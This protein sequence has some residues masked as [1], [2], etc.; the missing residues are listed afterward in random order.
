MSKQYGCH[1]RAPFK[2]YHL[3]TGADNLRKY[4]IPN[5]MTKDCQYRH[6]ELGKADPKCDG[7]K[8]REDR[9]EK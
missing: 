4:R 8:W 7:C 5:V 1:D 6:T 2:E 9:V 3:P